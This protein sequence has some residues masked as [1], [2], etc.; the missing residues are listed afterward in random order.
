MPHAQNNQMEIAKA[1]GV[2]WVASIEAGDDGTIRIGVKQGANGKWR[3]VF[4]HADVVVNPDANCFD[5]RDEAED[6]IDASYGRSDAG[7]WG[8]EWLSE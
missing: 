3:V 2:E 6:A 4:D 5:T 7:I 1:S 8:F